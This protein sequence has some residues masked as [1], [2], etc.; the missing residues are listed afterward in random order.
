[1]PSVQSVTMTCA[2]L[3]GFSLEERVNKLV[4]LANDAGGDDNITVVMVEL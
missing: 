4:S 3:S 1:M 2:A